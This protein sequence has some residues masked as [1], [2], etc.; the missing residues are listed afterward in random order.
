[1]ISGAYMPGEHRIDVRRLVEEGGGTFVEGRV[2]EIRTEARRFIL[3]SG[4]AISYDAASMCLGSETSGTSLRD[5]QEGPIPVKP[6]ANTAEIRRR[7]LALSKDR[8][9]SVLVVGGGAAGCEVAANALTLMEQLGTA[10]ALTVVERAETLLPE[11]PVKA[12]REIFR[13]L[14]GKGAEVLTNTTITHLGDGAARTEDGHEI[15][16]DLSVS[17]T[18]ASPPSVFRNSRLA[19]G[20]DG[21]L[22]VDRFL[23]STS[24]ERL[25]GGGDCVSFCGESL[26]KL[27]VFSVRQGPVIFRNLRATLEGAKLMKYRPQ[28]R[29]LYVLNLGDGTGLAVYGPLAWRGRLAWNIKNRIDTRFV[30]EHR[31]P[32]P[33]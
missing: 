21:G 6:V 22:Q 13:F 31:S 32:R 26:P 29:Y 15:P 23:R 1:V 11:A 12:Q 4:G 28:K 9:P 30:E 17:A 2:A 3:E 33:A 7:M 24:D 8:A 14:R 20:E 10:G 27:G 16:C 25:F 19:T 18:G 5:G